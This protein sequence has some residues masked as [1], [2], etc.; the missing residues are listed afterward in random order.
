[1]L[2]QVSCLRLGLYR[3]GRR[4]WLQGLRL[5]AAGY[6]PGVRYTLIADV[7]SKAITLRI[8]AGERTVSRKQVGASVYP[9]IDLDG[10]E[11]VLGDFER[12]QVT[13]AQRT[14]YIVP[15]PQELA[16]DERARRLLRKLI[17][18]EA[19]AFGSLSHGGGILDHAV[20]E[21]F[22]GAG[23]PTWLAWACDREAAY[24]QAS[25]ERNPVWSDRTLLVQ[26]EMEDVDL[27]VLP[28]IEVLVAGL[29]CTGASLAGRAKNRLRCAEEHESA[30][31]PVLAFLAVIQRCQ[32][33]VVLLENVVA[34]TDTAS[35]ALIRASLARWGYVVHEH[36]VGADLG[37]LEDRERLCVIA[38]SRGFE[39]VWSPRPLRSAEACLGDVLEPIGPDDEA[40]RRCEY[41]DAK[42][43]RDRA[44]GK[45][46]R[47][48]L[49]TPAATRIGTIGRGYA[50]WRST[51]PMVAHPDREG[52]R[53]LLTPKEHA[54]VKSV[55]PALVEGLGAT[56]AHDILGQSVL[57]APWMAVACMLA[58]QMRTW[59]SAGQ[60]AAA[61]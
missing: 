18:G 35:M 5:E 54:R 9:V 17:R 19:L 3:G 37:A 58:M 50:K 4:L 42:E 20:H 26:A 44:A 39:L 7:V 49:V 59:A 41:L 6:C 30:G 46:F 24:L 53:R 33:A 57:H 27:V 25:L 40:W 11:R 13:Y 38:V 28:R 36:V 61:V 31:T 51:E 43:A 15:H 60:K 48:Q 47:T 52:W 55:P 8:C 16:A 10:V 23:V 2:M 29:P 21:G 1:M 22:V 32:P 45:G 14:I 34:Y 56:L 12:V